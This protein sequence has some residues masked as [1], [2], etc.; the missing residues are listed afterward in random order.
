MR[1]AYVEFSDDFIATSATRLSTKNAWGLYV[2]RRWPQNT[3]KQAMAEWG[4]TDGEARGLVFAQVSQPT[5]DKIIDHKRGGFALGLL[6]LEIRTQTA[7]RSWLQTERERLS[8]EA[9]RAEAD[10]AA[11]G[12][13]A[14]CLPPALGLGALALI[15][16]TLGGVGSGA[17]SGRSGWWNG[18]TLSTAEIIEENGRKGNVHPRRSQ[19]RNRRAMRPA[20]GR[21]LDGRHPQGAVRFIARRASRGRGGADR[22]RHGAEAQSVIR[23]D[24]GRRAI[25]VLKR[26]TA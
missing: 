5:I 21:R 14:A 18:S 15:A 24:D 25:D 16:W 12:E 11:L 1:A 20:P 17:R 26:A 4:L 22:A 10:A 3:V 6:I 13:M 2:R 8:H 23:E 7:L 19:V 9:N